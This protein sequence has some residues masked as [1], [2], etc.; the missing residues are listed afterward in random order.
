MRADDLSG[1]EDFITQILDITLSDLKVQY[2]TGFGGTHMGR[3]YANG[4]EKGE[5]LYVTFVITL[6][7]LGEWKAQAEWSRPPEVDGKKQEPKW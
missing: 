7:M 3:M 2:C 6:P 4:G 5:T 1:P